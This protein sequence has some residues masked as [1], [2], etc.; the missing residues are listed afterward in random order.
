MFVHY[1][2]ASHIQGPPELTALNPLEGISQA[3]NANDPGTK[4]RHSPLHK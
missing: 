3:G 1:D 2:H 4:E